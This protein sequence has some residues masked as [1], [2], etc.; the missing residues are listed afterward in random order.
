MW[1][2]EEKT[3]L[4]PRLKGIEKR[5]PHKYVDFFAK[6]WGILAKKPTGGLPGGGEKNMR[7]NGKKNQPEDLQVVK[8]RKIQEKMAK[9]P[10]GGLTRG[11][12]KQIKSKNGKK[13]YWRTF[14]G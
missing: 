6:K 8:R 9:Y 10:T 4:N 3:P 2:I 1:I 7:K 11:E 12:K 13:T 5:A 14:K